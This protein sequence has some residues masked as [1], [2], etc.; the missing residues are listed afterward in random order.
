[1]TTR[2]VDLPAPTFR[3][4]VEPASLDA[5]KRTVRVTWTTGARVLRGGLFREP[6]HEELSTDPAHVRLGRLNA[7]APL[8]DGHRAWDTSAVVGTVE[9][10]SARV[11]DGKGTATVRFARAEDDPEADKVFRK[12][13]DGILRAVSVGYRVHK[14]ERVEAGDSAKGTLDVFRATDWEP[15]E[16]SAVAIGADAGAGFRSASQTVNRCTLEDHV[17]NTES[18]NPTPTPEVAAE[19]ERAAGIR[20][21]IARHKL[22]DDLADRLVADGVSLDAARAAILNH[23]ADLDEHTPTLS[24]IRDGYE[25]RAPIMPGDDY[26]SDFVRAA[27]D[28]QLLRAGIRMEKPHPGA[29]DVPAGIFDLARLVLSRSGKPGGGYLNR[30]TGPDLLKRAQTVGDFSSI[31][32]GSLGA[33]VRNGYENE[34]ASHRQWVNMVPVRDFRVQDRPILGAAPDLS[35]VAEHAEYKNGN[36]ADDM[37]S[38]TVTEYG[39]IVALSWEVLVNDNLGAFLRVQPALGQAARRKEADALYALFALNVGAGPT[40]DQDTVACFHANHNNLVGSAAF[41]ATQLGA[42]RS[43]LRKQKSKGGGYLSLQPVSL[44]VPAEKEQAAEVLVANAAR[45]PA[46]AA[47]SDRSVPAWISSLQVVVEPRLAS[48]GVFLAASPSQADHFELGLLE[49]NYGSGPTVE[50]DREFRKDTFQWKVKHV[51]GVK[52]TDWRGIV[53]AV[54]T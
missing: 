28:A 53:K 52:A 1:M 6:F 12:V 49:S 3:A 25:G 21:M 41:D 38:Y 26:A 17:D 11:A 22:G 46:N 42:M 54:V 29:R 32:I 7:G 51:F 30:T 40:M 37:A 34:P 35:A 2:T 18:S 45:P 4:A 50:E 23:L 10:G 15:Y 47:G 48:T 36:F 13:A 31:L 39:V 20:K 8:L 5:D 16:L 14:M 27:I 44:I 19:R 43:A 9:P 24:L 33:A